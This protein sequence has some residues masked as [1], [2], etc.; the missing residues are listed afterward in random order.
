[1]IGSL[2]LIGA[3]PGDPDLITLKGVKALQVAE[4]ILYDALVNESI[5]EHASVT[6]ER[7]FVGKRAGKHYAKQESINDLI[8][9]YAIF[10]RKLLGV[11]WY[12]E[13]WE[14]I[15]RHRV[16]RSI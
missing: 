1:L 14:S 2:T 10:Q 7:V 13:R 5:L 6:A 8:V 15:E 12:Y 11:D 4:V 9:K 3:G 16:S